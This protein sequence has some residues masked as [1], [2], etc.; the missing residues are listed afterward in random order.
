M[1]VL[2]A[3]YSAFSVV[4]IAVRIARAVKTDAAGISNDAELH[5]GPRERIQRYRDDIRRSIFVSRWQQGAEA[6]CP[7]IKEQWKHAARKDTYRLRC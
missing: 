3:V 6:V 7:P 4:A 1:M 5:I 2:A